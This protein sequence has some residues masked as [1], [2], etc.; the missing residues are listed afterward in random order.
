MKLGAEN[1]ECF[2]EKFGLQPEN[3]EVSC[4]F[5]SMKVTKS[6]LC[7]RKILLAAT[8]KWGHNLQ[9]GECYEAV[10]VQNEET[11]LN[12]NSRLGEGDPRNLSGGITE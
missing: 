1:T 12:Q 10:Q 9:Q 7:S 11:T 8:C 5:L 6:V 3:N 2:A 4:R